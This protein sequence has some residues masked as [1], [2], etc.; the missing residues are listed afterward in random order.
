MSHFVCDNLV[1]SCCQ[2]IKGMLVC[3][4]QLSTHFATHTMKAAV[5]SA[6]QRCT[7]RK[8]GSSQGRCVYATVKGQSV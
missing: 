2:K 5:G 4:H 3:L 1:L 8:Q 7:K 6:S